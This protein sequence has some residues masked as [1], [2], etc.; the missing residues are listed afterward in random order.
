MDY[1][2]KTAKSFENVYAL[3]NISIELYVGVRLTVIFLTLLLS[4]YVDWFVTTSNA[5]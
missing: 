4:A 1:S 2:R 3:S 5:E